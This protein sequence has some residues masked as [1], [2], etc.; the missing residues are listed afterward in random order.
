[1]GVYFNYIILILL[2]YNILISK[3]ENYMK[4]I[5]YALDFS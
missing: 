1:M 4:N 3:K 5:K 2:Y